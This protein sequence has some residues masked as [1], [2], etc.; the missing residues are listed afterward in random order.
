MTKLTPKCKTCNDTGEYEVLENYSGFHIDGEE[1]VTK[2]E[3]CEDCGIY[4][5]NDPL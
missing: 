3:V 2:K 1:P 5:L 4:M